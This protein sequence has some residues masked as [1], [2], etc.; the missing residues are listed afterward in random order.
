MSKIFV[1]NNK[2]LQDAALDADNDNTW[3]KQGTYF[4][5]GKFHR[6]L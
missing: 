5:D 1:S 3:L 4:Q 6:A 2:Y